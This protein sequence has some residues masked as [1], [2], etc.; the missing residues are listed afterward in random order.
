[1]TKP[2]IV[3][4]RG[5]KINITPQY[6]KEFRQMITTGGDTMRLS[7]PLQKLYDLVVSGYDLN[8]L[9]IRR[10]DAVV[11]SAETQK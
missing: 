3:D 6:V 5:V 11:V 9:S 7:P 8:S 1:M 4:E 10:S 2:H